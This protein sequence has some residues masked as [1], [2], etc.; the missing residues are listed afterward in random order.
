LWWSVLFTGII[1]FIL[2]IHHK[3]PPIAWLLSIIVIVSLLSIFD[4]RISELK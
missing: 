2:P 3:S 1:F 4:V